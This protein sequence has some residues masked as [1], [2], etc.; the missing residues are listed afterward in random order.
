MFYIAHELFT[1]GKYQEC[2]PMF[3]EISESLVDDRFVYWSLVFMGRCKQA[4]GTQG[5][6]EDFDRACTIFPDRAEAVYE[7]GKAHYI[8]GDLQEAERILRA[9]L[10]CKRPNACVRYEADKYFEATH[11]L[12]IELFMKQSRFNDSEELLTGLLMMGDS[13][14]YNKERAQENHLYSRFFNNAALEFVKARTIEK[15]ETL[16]IQLPNGYDGLGDNL[17]FSHI[18][19]IAKESGVFKEVLVSTRNVYKGKGYAEMVWNTNPYVDGFTDHPGTYSSIQMNRI[20]EKWNNIHPSLN[21]MDSI[22]LLHDLDD[23]KRGHTPECYYKPKRLE[24]L[25]DS[26]VLDAGAKTMDLRQVDP[27][28]LLEVLRDHGIFPDYVI[29]SK[30]S[31]A[32]LSF[33]GIERIEPGSIEEWADV[34]FS[35]KHY[36]C[37][38]S[39]GYWLS[40]SLG[41]KAKHIWVESK[42]LP[43]WSFLGHE[44]IFI[45]T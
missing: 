34:M 6:L 10:L 3:K 4:L 27:E 38:N 37:F 16:V 13:N 33:P 31:S 11:E 35:A 8:L 42:N 19:R 26:V 25:K 23:G 43:A 28:R 24:W 40:G 36:V 14:L 41:I 45:N 15:G 32:T 22:M 18:P 12:L 20:L 39:G 30:A 17:V 29:E 9:A 5:F 21:L 7:T 2:L 1:N 44:N